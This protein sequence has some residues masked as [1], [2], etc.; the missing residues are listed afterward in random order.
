MRYVLVLLAI[1][2]CGP[3]PDV[4]YA[5]QFN[6]HTVTIRGGLDMDGKLGPQLPKPNQAAEAQRICA[7]V[8][9]A[10]VHLSSAPATDSDWHID[11]LF[12]CQ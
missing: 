8:N 10:A 3:A 9:K 4:G 11:H 2:A 1:A 6:G 12:A 7:S 5:T